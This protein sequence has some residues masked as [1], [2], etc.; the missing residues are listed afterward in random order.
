MRRWRRQNPSA[1]RAIDAAKYRRIKADPARW[2]RWLEQS[3]ERI[4]RYRRD[5]K[6]RAIH[7]ADALRR[8]HEAMNDPQKRA[9]IRAQQKARYQRHK[10][11]ITAKARA[12]REASA[13]TRG[14]QPR[15][16]RDGARLRGAALDREAFNAL[17]CGVACCAFHKGGVD[18]F[19]LHF[20]AK[21]EGSMIRSRA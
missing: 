3:R 8:Y 16:A 10:G 4:R 13:K 11:E 18:I 5:P 1:A 21:H 6:T 19:G 7:N 20:E 14:A 2:A 12:A 9:K 17:A 15:R